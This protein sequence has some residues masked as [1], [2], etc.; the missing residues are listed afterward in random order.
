MAKLFIS[1]AFILFGALGTAYGVLNEQMLILALGI[2]FVAT[3]IV[4]A[5]AVMFDQLMEEI[6]KIKTSNSINNNNNPEV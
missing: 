4:A 6:E 3:G 2:F 1:I 5:I